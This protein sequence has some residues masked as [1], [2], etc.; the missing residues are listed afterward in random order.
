MISIITVCF[1]AENTIEAT[2]LSVL[3]SSLSDF[4]LVIVD[5][6]SNDNTI[7]IINNYIS[8]ISV[9]KSERDLGIYDAMNK[10]LK[11]AN[12][13]WIYFLNSGD[14]LDKNFSPSLNK[15]QSYS[16]IAFACEYVYDG[17][18]VNYLP[19]ELSLGRMP[20]SHQALLIKREVI[21]NYTFN[22]KFKVAADFDQIVRIL[23]NV[24]NKMFLTN[25]K[26]AII[27]GNGFS[28]NN[29]NRYLLEY[30]LIIKDNW[31][32]SNALLWIVKKIVS[33]SIN[34]GVKY[35]LGANSTNKLRKI[36]E[37]YNF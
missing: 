11:L 4:E 22:L 21:V 33:S 27:D 26:I 1:N 6:G 16:I 13:D 12:G 20:A 28:T 7:N 3:E 17:Y 2:I 37:K 36:K 18:T 10:G 31:G 19:R 14:L 23:S 9:F 32:N 30:F 24:K 25:S 8:Y 15:F 29:T 5:G 34:K 35:F